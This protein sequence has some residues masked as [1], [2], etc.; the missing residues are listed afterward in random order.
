MVNDKKTPPETDFR[1]L[2]RD[3]AKVETTVSISTGYKQT[4]WLR[5][6][7]IRVTER[8]KPVAGVWELAAYL[9]N[10]T[11]PEHD[12]AFVLKMNLIGVSLS[13]ICYGVAHLTG[14]VSSDLNDFRVPDVGYDPRKHPKAVKCR[15]KHCENKGHIIVPEGFYVPPPNE[16]LFSLVRG[17]RV[18]IVTGPKE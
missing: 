17:A 14:W 5:L 15:D 10:A 4:L 9:N 16:T 2:C 13:M 6:G 3:S 1:K 8:S 18:E 7:Q 11:D 12:S